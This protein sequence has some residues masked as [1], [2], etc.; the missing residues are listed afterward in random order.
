MR[1]EKD[2]VQ[3]AARQQR[4]AA[5]APVVEI[6]GDDQWR[7]RRNLAFDDLAQQIQLALTVRFAQ[8]QVHADRVHLHR[9]CGI[10]ITQCSMPRSS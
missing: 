10:A 9:A 6:A 5:P 2:L 8:T 7:V 3:A 4:V 1:F